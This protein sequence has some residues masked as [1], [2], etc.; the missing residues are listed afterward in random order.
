MVADN[1][2]V[3]GREGWG[4]FYTEDLECTWAQRHEVLG[5]QL[6]LKGV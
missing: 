2:K 6:L 4:G 3:G 5:R 1:E